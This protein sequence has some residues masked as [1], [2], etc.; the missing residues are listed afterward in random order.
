MPVQQ[1]YDLDNNFGQDLILAAGNDLANVSDVTKS[2]QRVLRRLLTS[3]GDYI[4]HPTYGAGLPAYVGK[5]LTNDVYAAIQSTI[6]SQIFLEASVAKT[7]TPVIKLQT[8]QHGL[9]VQINYTVN[10][11]GQPVVLAFTVE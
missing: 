7:P 1:T 11:S 4:W 2:Q 5:A 10:P 3:P 6:I 8:I 9:L